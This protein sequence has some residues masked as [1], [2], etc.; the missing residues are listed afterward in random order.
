MVVCHDCPDGDNPLC[1]N[2][3]HLF[4]GTQGDNMRDCRDKGRL[5]DVKGSLHPNSK[6]TEDR[7][8]RIRERW[9]SRGVS[10]AAIGVEF[11]VSKGTVQG[12]VNGRS[13]RHVADGGAPDSA[14][15]P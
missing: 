14:R 6:L 12:I 11:G 5:A 7:V 3:G 8:L 13:W 10:L 9:A 15:K 1:V 2:P 4:L